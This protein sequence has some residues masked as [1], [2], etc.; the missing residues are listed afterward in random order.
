[1]KLGID[2]SRNR[3]GGA[4]AYLVGILSEKNKYIDCFNEIHL[5]VPLEIVNKIPFRK[6]L[7]IHTLKKR[8]I[9]FEIFWQYYTLN[10]ILNHL[11]INLLFTT[12]SATFC[13]FSRNILLN[14]DVL[15]Y[16]SIANINS[17]YFENL[18]NFLIRSVQSHS[19]KNAIGII[20][21]SQY[22][23]KLITSYHKIKNIDTVIIPHGF[24]SEYL[25]IYI[26]KQHRS[27]FKVVYTSN[28]LPYKNFENVLEAI[29]SVLIEKGNILN[30]YFIGGGNSIEY[31]RIKTNVKKDVILC[32]NVFFFDFLNK[33]D[34]IKIYKGSDIFLYASECEAFGIT[35]LEALATGMPIISSNLS[36]L[37]E[38]I[39][40]LAVE[41]NPRN[42]DDIAEGIIKMITQY[43]HFEN[44]SNLRVSRAQ[45]YSWNICSEKTFNFLNKIAKKN[46]F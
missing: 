14:Q 15:P 3:S 42:P 34:I 8:S 30:F 25:N 5:F 31:T 2:A 40:G 44:D 18:R 36:G 11:K 7:Y 38:I 17:N 43:K 33:Q 16:D 6:N 20:F 24:D 39:N 27:I 21:L 26:P 1:M 45:S 41:I 10:K 23:R 19:F 12:D 13:N 32:N 37:L 35:L 22:S 28:Y 29:K 9:V 46:E 4:I